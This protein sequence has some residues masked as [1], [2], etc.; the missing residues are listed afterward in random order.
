MVMNSGL[1]KIKRY[2][3][4]EGSSGETKMLARNLPAGT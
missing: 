4:A 3:M 2:G 1:E